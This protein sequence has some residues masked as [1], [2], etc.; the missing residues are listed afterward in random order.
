M[1]SRVKSNH[2][3]LNFG[4]LRADVME[5]HCS[6]SFTCSVQ[7]TSN[8]FFCCPPHACC[9]LLPQVLKDDFSSVEG[10]RSFPGLA[11]IEAKVERMTKGL[12]SPVYIFAKEKV[13]FSSPTSFLLPP[14]SH[15]P[16]F[17]AWLPSGLPSAPRISEAAAVG[18]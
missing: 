4:T 8:H 15:V 13:R 2:V 17:G 12:G 18:D 6:F 9:R 5:E 10:G 11:G 3:V 16:S 7:R 1:G 14:A